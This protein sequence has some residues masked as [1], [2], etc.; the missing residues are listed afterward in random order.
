MKKIC[1]V[2]IFLG[3]VALIASL[4]SHLGVGRSILISTGF[5]A[6][7]FLGHLVFVNPSDGTPRGHR[8]SRRNDNE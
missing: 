7:D 3:T 4:I 6:V 8:F 5:L 2:G 1:P